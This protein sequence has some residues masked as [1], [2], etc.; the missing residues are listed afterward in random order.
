MAQMSDNHKILDSS[1]NNDETYRDEGKYNNT[2]FNNDNYKGYYHFILTINVPLNS[3]LS[4]SILLKF[5]FLNCSISSLFLFFILWQT[6]F[7]HTPATSPAHI[8]P[9]LT[10]LQPPR[11][12][13]LPSGRHLAPLRVALRPENRMEAAGRPEL[14]AIVSA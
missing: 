7:L 11:H 14:T 3:V 8:C 10:L 6:P 5:I 4:V 1:I 9:S 12:P 13:P 2:D